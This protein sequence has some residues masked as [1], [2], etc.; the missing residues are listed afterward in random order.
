MGTTSL[1][2]YLRA[3]RAQ[4]RPEDVGLPAGTRRRVEGLRREE[5]A[6]LAGISPEYY[7]RL[8]QGRDQH[9]SDQVLASLAGALRLDAD[10]TAYLEA[11]ARPTRSASRKA[12]AEKVSP[13]MQALIDG[14]PTTAAYVQGRRFTVLAANPLA[15]ALT[16]HFALGAS[17]IRAAFLAPDMHTLYRDWDEMTARTVP[18]MRSVVAG[19]EGEPEVAA[20]I[21]ELSLRSERFRTLWARH[22][23]KVRDDGPTTFV[24]P[25]VG[26]L[27]LRFQK[28]VL[29]ESGQ[30]LVT[31]HAEPG[32]P[33]EDPFR[34]LAAL[35][36]GTH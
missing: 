10:G 36:A 33:S 19:H 35:A 29:P 3:R 31:Y 23:V 32:S 12:L 6:L 5:V 24:H 16:R 14:W 21:G 30:L 2:E 15:V 7:L 8:E 34:I 22:D 9:P 20:L 11:I 18:F 1:G 27:D 26:P 28:F 25:H 13:H 4:L 17:P